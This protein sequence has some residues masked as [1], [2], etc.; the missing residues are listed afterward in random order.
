MIEATI[1][2]SYNICRLCSGLSQIQNGLFI[3]NNAP[4]PNPFSRSHSWHMHDKIMIGIS[5]VARRVVI[6]SDGELFMDLEVL[7]VQLFEKL[8][9]S[10]FAKP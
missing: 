7:D 8:D 1:S 5:K 2:I 4:A 6:Y 3:K 9:D 10:T